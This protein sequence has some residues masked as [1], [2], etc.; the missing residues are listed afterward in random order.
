M[1][2]TKWNWKMWPWTSVIFKEEE[3]EGEE[4]E[5]ITEV[6]IR[7]ADKNLFYSLLLA[8]AVELDIQLKEVI[9]KR[10]GNLYCKARDIRTGRSSYYSKY[11][12]LLEFKVVVYGSLKRLSYFYEW[13]DE[14]K[15]IEYY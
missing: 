11:V 8:K 15:A 10:R 6:W 12:D 13:L 9:C 1:T 3:D 5:S 14:I 2:T 4:R 7:L